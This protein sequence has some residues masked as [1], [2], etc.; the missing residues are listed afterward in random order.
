MAGLF[1][2]IRRH[3]ILATTTVIIIALSIPAYR[4]YQL[5]ISYGPGGP[6]YNALGWFFSR[7]LVTP[8]GQEMFSTKVY[9]RRILAGEDTSYLTFVGGQIPHR[10][11]VTPAVGPHVVPQ[12]QIDQLS[13]RSIQKVCFQS[14]PSIMEVLTKWKKSN[15]NSKRHSTAWPAKI[16][17]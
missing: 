12:R 17:T 15:R 9:E 8:F 2:V 7:F 3:S 1:S 16:L 10:D 13:S 4:D 11:G 5:F 14:I 6:P